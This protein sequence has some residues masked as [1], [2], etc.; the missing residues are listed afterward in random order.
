MH[1]THPVDYRLWLARWAAALFCLAACHLAAA[2]DTVQVRNDAGTQT[3][4]GK[5]LVTAKDGG[6]LVKTPD[7]VMH[8]VPPEELQNKTHDE[9][10]FIPLN[11]DALAADLLKTLPAGFETHRTKHYVI[12]YGTSREYAQWCGALLERL[13]AAFSNYWSKKGLEL[14]EAEFLSPVIVFAGQSEYAQFAAPEIGKGVQPPIGYYSMK[15]NRITTYDLTGT[16]KLIGDRRGSAA[17]IN[18]MLSQPAAEDAVATLIHEATHQIAFNSGLHQRFADIPGWL[19]EGLA[20]VFETPDLNSAKGW[21][22]MGSVNYNRLAT[23]RESRAPRGADALQSLLQDDKKIRDPHTALSAYADAWA[24]NYYLM[25]QRPK[26][27][28][29][30]LK[31]LAAKPP[32][33]WDTPE[34]RLADFRAAFDTDLT[35]LAADF[36]RQMQKIK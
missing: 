30:Y 15:T 5:I 20:M 29:A 19:S 35:T 2:M 16:E 28:V 1:Q 17:Q 13:H 23:F 31:R 10:P 4:V 9:A 7:G 22:G 3:L 18:Q 25:Q 26:Q 27:Y 6:L 24:L 34:E 11:A 33:V 12:A 21:R 32:L 8:S 14:H 36:S